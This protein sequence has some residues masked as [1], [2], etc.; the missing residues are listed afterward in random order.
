M[1]F[2]SDIDQLITITGMVIRTSSLVPEMAEALFRCSVCHSTATVEVERGRIAEPT[3]CTHCNTN[4]SYT[5]VHNRSQYSDKQMI[6]LQESPD[7]MP[8]GQTPHTVVLYAHDAMVDSVQPGDRVAVTGIY[9]AVPARVSPIVR[10]IKSVY[11]THVD[12]VHFRKTDM[13]RLHGAGG[14][15]NDDG[16][17][18]DMVDK[19]LSV[20]A[21]RLALIEELAKKPDVYERLARGIAPSIYENEDIKKGILMQLFG[22]A[23]KDMSGTGRG[24]GFRYT[25]LSLLHIP[26]ID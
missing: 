23:R 12:V 6:K 10:N 9:R 19:P 3:L 24:G 14:G 2:I 4:H 21:E 8:A 16:N 22:G 25:I 18:E 13:R 7:D 11:K 1:N 26:M 17:V 15:D 20:D 5:L